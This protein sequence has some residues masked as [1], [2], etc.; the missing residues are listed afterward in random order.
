MKG[1]GIGDVAD[2]VVSRV[3]VAE[4]SLQWNRIA[5]SSARRREK[6]KDASAAWLGA[7][8]RAA[9]MCRVVK[10]SIGNR[11]QSGELSPI[12]HERLAY[13]TNVHP[14]RDLAATRAALEEHAVAVKARYS[15]DQPMAVGLWLAAEPAREL[16]ENP[17]ELASFAR[18]LADEGLVP[19]TFNGF[20]YGDFHQAVVK[21]RVYEPA[22]WSEGRARY[23]QD[24]ARILDA[25]L[26]AGV[27]GTISTLPLGW[28]PGG[29]AVGLLRRAAEQLEVVVEFLRR[30]ESESG[31]RIVL[32]LEP[33]P[34]CLLQSSRDVVEFFESYL[35]PRR[36]S[37]WWS[38]HLGVC[39][40]ICHSAVM[41]EPQVEA[42]QRYRESKITIGK[43]QIS[44]AVR[45]WLE[46]FT[47]EERAAQRGELAAFAE[48]RYLHQTVW[49]SE[50]GETRFFADLPSALAD[51]DGL[52]QSE[53]RTHFHVP[54]FLKQFGRLETTQD[55]IE[56]FLSALG[57]DEVL[58]FEV[59]TYAWSVLPEELRE[60]SLAEG[61]AREMAWAAVR[62]VNKA[63]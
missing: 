22:W 12:V 46:G 47:L 15:P 20:P 62:L 25:L 56:R 33:E 45:M 18:W 14:G 2:I 16:L 52:E 63:K 6:R 29:D 24:L 54:V 42:L 13:C 57:K 10:N 50:S 26:P 28:P 27:V 32:C 5:T 9:R 58:H 21:H 34:G 44:A 49:R 31:R 51:P 38:H 4:S 19:C 7:F 48:D 8:F 37:D 1:N 23:T 35:W 61:I 53:W 41:F 11:I 17:I 36:E 3:L 59:E 40:D 39:H 43:V 60:A 30:L 55:D